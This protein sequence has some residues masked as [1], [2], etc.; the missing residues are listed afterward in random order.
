MTAHPHPALIKFWL[1]LGGVAWI[2]IHKR[3]T[4]ETAKARPTA[5]ALAPTDGPAAADVTDPVADWSTA[6][7]AAL[8]SSGYR[9]DEARTAVYSATQGTP[10]T[11]ESLT[12]L[13]VAQRLVGP[14]PGAVTAPVHM[15]TGTRTTPFDAPPTNSKS[16]YIDAAGGGY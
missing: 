13:T 10:L 9:S 7:I 14:R 16:A 11:A 5:N 12:L 2:L 4:D 6:A 3:M 8:V 1:V 15:L